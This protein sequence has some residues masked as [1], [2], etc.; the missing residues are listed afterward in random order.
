MEEAVSL[1][2]C[3]METVGIYL[4]KER[5]AK[6]IS[7]SEVSRLTKIS[8]FYL[9]YI[10]KDEFEKL[11]QG[12]YIRGYISS[13]SRL[14]GGNVDEALKLYDSLNEKQNQTEKFQTEFLKHIGR[15]DPSKKPK[16]EVWKQST[17][18]LI[19]KIRSS[20]N[21][22]SSNLK[23]KSASLK[24]A[25]PPLKKIFIPFKKIP[26]SLIAISSKRKARAFSSMLRGPST[27]KAG[28]SIKAIGPSIQ[29][30]RDAFK[31]IVPIFKT[32]AL[33]VVTNFRLTD[34]R[35]WLVVCVALFGAGILVLA[36][37]GFYHLFIYPKNPP[38]IAEMHILKDKAPPPLPAMATGKK[39]FESRSNDASVTSNERLEPT[40]KKDLFALSR[41]ADQQQP[42]SSS[43]KSDAATPRETPNST[44][45]PANRV[46][47]P[48]SRSSSPADNTTSSRTTA[49]KQASVLSDQRPTAAIP[50]PE[51]ATAGANLKVLRAGICL[52][53]KDRMPVGIGTSFTASVRRVY[54]WNQI[55]AK[56]I[57][58]QIRHI[59][60]FK[61]NKISDV[62]LDVRSTHWRT[63]SF[64]SIS[65]NRY[66][67]EWR[68]DIT[69]A[70]G[71]VL[72]RLF[73]EIR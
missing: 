29:K 36:G 22:V 9:D 15:D 62:T 73:F 53:I 14:I 12:P 72:R 52:T 24:A 65:N 37:F 5:E 31:A 47:T 33:A 41:L 32:T 42:S 45:G 30:K 16:R 11:P 40:H 54:V 20:F 19:G 49:G 28:A 35:T 34:R 2:D 23:A 55:G 58:S 10:E 46:T 25:T 26:S 18:S 13:Y 44:S 66:R 63:W 68:V 67:G 38:I 59:Y 48:S 39:R 8:E 17:V 7:L 61:G 60:Y 56:Q 4:K 51:S 27:K 50:S 71:K 21:S 1:G 64:Q 43:T 57:P 6:D 69:S 70:G 3:T